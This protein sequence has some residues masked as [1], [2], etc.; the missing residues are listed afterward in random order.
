MFFEYE[1]FSDGEYDCYVKTVSTYFSMQREISFYPILN[2][3]T[4]LQKL[5]FLL[6]HML[7]NLK[8]KAK[9]TRVRVLVKDFNLRVPL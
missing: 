2:H 5:K 6:S 7:Q 3:Y 8:S 9:E 1:K 4:I